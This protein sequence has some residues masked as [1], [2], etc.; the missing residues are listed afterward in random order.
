MSFGPKSAACRFSVVGRNQAGDEVAPGPKV[1]P[2]LCI[3]LRSLVE[4]T[5]Q[6]RRFFSIRGADAIDGPLHFFE[7]MFFV[8]MREGEPPRRI[9]NIGAKP[10]GDFFAVG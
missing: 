8:S 5:Q 10:S 3:I 9:N 4:R 2:R 6:G 7:Q 1:A